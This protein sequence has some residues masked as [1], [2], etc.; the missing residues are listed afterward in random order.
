M[1][2]NQLIM[3]YGLTSRYRKE[4]GSYKN[5]LH[6]CYKEKAPNYK[7]YGGRGIS[8]CPEWLVSFEAFLNDIGPAPTSKHS[9]D[10][11]DNEG[12]Y[13]KEN[14]RW[15]TEKE[16]KRNRGDFNVK[17]T[18]NGETLLAIEWSEKLDMPFQLITSR[19]NMGWSDERILTT[20]NIG[21]GV[22]NRRAVINTIT[23]DKFDTVREAAKSIGMPEINL[24]GRLIGRVKNNTNFI[25]IEQYVKSNNNQLNLL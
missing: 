9:L 13:C 15:A 4:Y 21:L 6:R 16:Q 11:V 18:L 17:L 10:R 24:R 19:R 8:V 1:Y 3:T 22:H 2:I 25:Y 20:P 23:L 7:W 14:C 5:M 12:N